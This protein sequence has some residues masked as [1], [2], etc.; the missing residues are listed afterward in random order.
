MNLIEK[1][2]DNFSRCFWLGDYDCMDE[3]LLKTT[4]SNLI[5]LS[6]LDKQYTIEAEEYLKECEQ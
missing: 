2:V 3:K 6:Q 4:I 1:E 5:I